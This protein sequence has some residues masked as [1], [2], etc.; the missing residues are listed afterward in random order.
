MTQTVSRDDITK[1]EFIDYSLSLEDK[2][3]RV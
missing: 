1:Q 2:L 3:A